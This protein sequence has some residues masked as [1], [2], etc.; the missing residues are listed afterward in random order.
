[1]PCTQVVPPTGGKENTVLKNAEPAAPDPAKK[2]AAE[3]A[4]MNE[5]FGKLKDALEKAFDGLVG[6]ENH[7]DDAKSLVK[8]LESKVSGGDVDGM[9]IFDLENNLQLGLQVLKEFNSL[10]IKDDD[11]NNSSLFRTFNLILQG[12]KRVEERN[13]AVKVFTGNIHALK[14]TLMNER[15]DLIK[16]VTE[17]GLSQKIGLRKAL[18][19]EGEP[20]NTS[21]EGKIDDVKNW[22]H[23]KLHTET[24]W[25][26]PFEKLD[27]ELLK[28]LQNKYQETDKLP[29]RCNETRGMIQKTYT[30]LGGTGKYNGSFGGA[31]TKKE[32]E[33]ISQT[34]GI[35]KLMNLVEKTDAWSD[36]DNLDISILTKADENVKELDAEL[37][38]VNGMLTRVDVTGRKKLCTDAKALAERADKINT[39]KVPAKASVLTQ[40]KDNL[41][42]CEKMVLEDFDLTQKTLQATITKREKEVSDLEKAVS[43]ADSA[44]LDEASKLEA[45]K[46]SFKEMK[47]RIAGLQKVTDIEGSFKKRLGA[48]SSYCSVQGLGDFEEWDEKRKGLE[49]TIKNLMESA[50]SITEGVDIESANLEKMQSINF[51]LSNVDV[52]LASGSREWEEFM[53]QLRK[54]CKDGMENFKNKV[55]T[56]LNQL[57]GEIEKFQQNFQSQT[58]EDIDHF[59][60]KDYIAEFK[61]ELDSFLKLNERV[62]TDTELND[63]DTQAFKT[64]WGSLEK[65]KTKLNF[66]IFRL[67][68]GTDNFKGMSKE[69][70]GFKKSLTES[71]F[72]SALE[73]GVEKQTRTEMIQRIGA[74]YENLLD[75]NVTHDELK[76]DFEIVKQECTSFLKSVN[77]KRIGKLNY[78]VKDILMQI[79]QEMDES[80]NQLQFAEFAGFTEKM[81]LKQPQILSLQMLI[82]GLES[83]SDT[84]NLEEITQREEDL[85]NYKTRVAEY[86]NEMEDIK[87]EVIDKAASMVHNLADEIVNLISKIDNND[88]VV[89]EGA[90]SDVLKKFK[91]AATGA[92]VSLLSVQA[93]ATWETLEALIQNYK[94]SGT[95]IIKALETVRETLEKGMYQ[96]AVSNRDRM[97]EKFKGLDQEKGNTHQQLYNQTNEKI[98]QIVHGWLN[99]TLNASEEELLEISGWVNEA[100]AKFETSAPETQAHA[101]SPALQGLQVLEAIVGNSESITSHVNT[102][103]AASA[104]LEN[105]E[106]SSLPV[107]QAALNDGSNAKSLD[108]A[109]SALHNYVKSMATAFKY[110]TE[111]HQKNYESANEQEKRRLDTF[112]R[113]ALREQERLCDELMD[114]MKELNIP[115]ATNLCK[116]AL[117]VYSASIHTILTDLDEKKPFNQELNVTTS[118]VDAFTA[119]NIRVLITQNKSG[120]LTDNEDLRWWKTWNYTKALHENV[121]RFLQQEDPSAEMAKM[122]LKSIL[123]ALRDV[124][125]MVKIGASLKDDQ[126]DG[127]L[128]TGVE[129]GEERKEGL[130][131]ILT[132][133]FE[134]I[135]EAV[136][137]VR[138]EFNASGVKSILQGVQEKLKILH[139]IMTVHIIENHNNLYVL[140]IKEKMEIAESVNNGVPV[141][142]AQAAA[143]HNALEA[144]NP[145]EVL[146][147]EE[148][149]LKRMKDLMKDLATNSD[150]SI[151]AK[152]QRNI[153]DHF[154]NDFQ[155]KYKNEEMLDLKNNTNLARR[156]SFLRNAHTT[157][158]LKKIINLD[159]ITEEDLRDVKLAFVAAVR[160]LTANP[161]FESGFLDGE[162]D[163]SSFNHIIIY[164]M[165]KKLLRYKN[166]E[167]DDCK[168]MLEHNSKY[169][170]MPVL[171]APTYA[172]LKF[173]DKQQGFSQT[174]AKYV[175][176]GKSEDGQDG[177]VQKIVYDEIKKHQTEIKSDYLPVCESMYLFSLFFVPFLHYATKTDQAKSPNVWH[178]LVLVDE[179]TKNIRRI[180]YGISLKMIKLACFHGFGKFGEL[181][182]LKEK[183]MFV[184]KIVTKLLFGN[185]TTKLETNDEIHEFLNSVKSLSIPAKVSAVLGVATS[186][187]NENELYAAIQVSTKEFW[188]TFYEEQYGKISKIDVKNTFQKVNIWKQHM[189]KPASASEFTDGSD[190]D[191]NTASDV[192]NVN[193]EEP[194]REA[195]KLKRVKGKLFS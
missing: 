80:E 170:G 121:H 148:E 175:S 120:Q 20:P 35:A 103:A 101:P 15:K 65:T 1:M 87:K 73:D 104:A 129:I 41:K 102:A 147:E 119:D 122:V 115:D 2:P 38:K 90:D 123:Q 173:G 166:F 127:Y 79:S 98:N 57:N 53:K 96:K 74:T 167:K 89:K 68:A 48:W 43:E 37:K 83:F 189:R 192:V 159:K 6:F 94:Q 46:K 93:T 42:S 40:M 18:K 177:V 3:F 7:K 133:T 50:R 157:E 174:Y 178:D 72:S 111:H 142:E 99:G 67:S 191:M 135:K 185:N 78:G 75:Q 168:R 62:N 182:E 21:Y 137:V 105:P 143:G 162:V 16:S 26:E 190:F 136:G 126:M 8:G 85:K 36:G 33:L 4:E 181:K 55:H 13:L 10:G 109:C 164:L 158:N 187:N 183:I 9:E 152:I 17:R 106:V 30:D 100:I 47:E 52:K 24:M 140:K 179:K 27:K 86:R 132:E 184:C 58:Q 151:F 139:A 163:G 88:A 141:Q 29:G 84:K 186:W 82:T 146:E 95:E 32:T 117:D 71:G 81:T 138:S 66:L 54:E 61:K 130:M 51:Q 153:I 144:L 134:M 113:G 160:M 193:T 25:K 131:K 12:V 11:D 19:I 172:F 171:L 124:N 116:A 194:E 149:V 156:L 154:L 34:A 45:A 188:I 97:A 5:L 176:D 180:F 22:S 60:L 23:F 70:L 69:L 91:E 14:E 118:L 145:S 59:K 128:E 28:E 107:A 161:D 64:T 112:L 155:K 110:S 44:E 76:K 63:E 31:L 92:G 125:E 195:K 114:F 169:T 150:E 56:S 165:I 77:E 49:E 108:D 39:S